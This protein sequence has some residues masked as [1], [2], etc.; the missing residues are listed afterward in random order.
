MSRSDSSRWWVAAEGVLGACIVIMPWTLG[1]AL[2]MALPLMAAFS[3]AAVVCWGAGAVRHSRRVTLHGVLVVPLALALVAAFQLVPLPPGVLSL[4]SPPAAELREFALVPLGLTGWRPI[5]V[6]PPSTARA[7]TRLLA[8]AL[9]AFTALQLGRVDAVRRR[10]FS[11][12]A[13]SGVLVALTGLGH[14]LAG[15]E[16]LFG[17]HHFVTTLSIV[18]PF[19]NVNHLAAFLT[20]TG[21]AALGLGLSSESRDGLVAWL[22]AAFGCGVAVFLSLSRGGIATFAVTWGLVGAA[23]L[24]LKGGGLKRVVPWVVIA[25]TMAFAGLLAFE[26]L[27]AR[28]D[29][30]SSVEKLSHSKVE[31][32]PMLWSGISPSGRLGMGTGAFELGFPRWQTQQLDVTFTHPENAVLQLVADVGVPLGSALGLFAIWL[33]RRMWVGVWSQHA[34]RTV[35]LGAAGVAMHDVFDFALE[36]HA[37]APAVAI[38]LG[39]VASAQRNERQASGRAL[40]V[41]LVVLALMAFGLWAGR[42]RHLDAEA[43]LAELIRARAPVSE[44]RERAVAAIDRHPSD[45]VLYARMASDVASRGDPREAL[46]WANRQAFLRPA[47]PHA[48]VS[49]AHALLRLKEPAQALAQLKRA[50]EL[51]DD[52]SIALGVA[53]ASKAHLLDRLVIDRPGFLV[54]L[55][56]NATR[57]LSPAETV[58][59]LE[60][61]VGSGM[62]DETQAEARWLLVQQE[63]EYGDPSRALEAFARLPLAQQQRDEET[64]LEVRLL[65]RVGRRDEAIE[66]LSGLLTRRPSDLDAI[67]AQVDLLSATNR[68]AQA[69]EVLERARPFVDGTAGRTALFEREATLYAQEERWGRALEALQT[70]SRIS[71]TRADLHYRMADMFERMGS[72]HSALDEVRRG[73]V[74]DTPAGVKAT[75]P[76]VERLERALSGGP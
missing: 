15:A 60:S 54:L 67:W 73:R 36:L 31:L 34:E 10:L 9:L 33:T 50:W 75:D 32:W 14:F 2:P 66:V 21:T 44:V 68:L 71:P 37:V 59:I 16:S 48:A 64:K 22:T 61:V 40:G 11:A 1:G 42:P 18:T 72:L 51:G 69:H 57:Q 38:C 46:A 19:G 52:Q 35:L 7:L 8:L 30:V 13:L 74:L 5:S 39:L 17:V 65:T 4:F 27:A 49:A 47:D 25:G 23:F 6:D 29:T 58:A 45:W 76:T 70:A 62:S 43:E 55:W 12:T 41:G 20:F 3:V 28:I 24:S 63:A 26:Q 53:V 56:R